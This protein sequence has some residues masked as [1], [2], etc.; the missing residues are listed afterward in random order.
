MIEANRWIAW[1]HH[2]NAVEE[3]P[4]EDDS[5]CSV[6]ASR[7]NECLRA[8]IAVV[9]SEAHADQRAAR[10]R[11]EVVRS[12]LEDG[13]LKFRRGRAARETERLAVHL[14]RM[15]TCHGRPDCDRHFLRA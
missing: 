7:R 5:R 15:R 4:H 3:I 8:R 2:C 12:R 9:D 13:L 14:L 11:R 6:L 1:S 10:T